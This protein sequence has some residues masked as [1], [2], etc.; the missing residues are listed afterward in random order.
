MKLDCDLTSEMCASLYRASELP[1]SAECCSK[2]FTF[3][4]FPRISS[5]FLFLLPSCPNPDFAQNRWWSLTAIR[6]ALPIG[7]WP[8]RFGRNEDKSVL[9]V[10]LEELVDG[11]CVY[12]GGCAVS[13]TSV[14]RACLYARD[15]SLAWSKSDWSGGVI[16]NNKWEYERNADKIETYCFFGIFR[17]D[18]IRGLLTGL[19]IMC[20]NRFNIYTYIAIQHC[21]LLGCF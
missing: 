9:E 2:S 20:L 1:N 14:A 4:A 18:W 12:D 21:V 19:F 3:T 6:T 8:W 13:V 10:E 15:A 16:Y 17:D 11:S 7:P 5:S